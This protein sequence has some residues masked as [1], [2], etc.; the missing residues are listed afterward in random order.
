MANEE[1]FMASSL[2]YAC[3][4]RDVEEGAHRAGVRHLR[5]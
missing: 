4:P 3:V 1:E 5:G 2:R